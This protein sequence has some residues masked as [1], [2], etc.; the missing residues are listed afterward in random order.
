MENHP[1]KLRNSANL[2]CYLVGVVAL[3]AAAWGSTDYYRHVVFDNS[4]NTD[5]YFYSQGMANGSSFLE[6]KDRRL[7]VETQDISDAAECASFAMGVTTRRRVG[8]GDSSGRP[9]QPFPGVS[10]AQSLFLVLCTQGDCG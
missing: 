1:R 3:T 6:L 10:G 4:L 8:S 2:M 9:S 7:P 5:T